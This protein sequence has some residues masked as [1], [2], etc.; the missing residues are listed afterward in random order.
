MLSCIKPGLP[1]HLV[2]EL[3]VGAVDLSYIEGM[4]M[5]S[6]QDARV[7]YAHMYITPIHALR[8]SRQVLS[9]PKILLK[10][11]KQLSTDS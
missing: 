3:N 2:Q 7:N 10:I 11:T 9:G 1:T 4:V 6:C 8:F 5:I